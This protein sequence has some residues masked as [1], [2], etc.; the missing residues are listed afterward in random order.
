MC[1]AGFPS[2]SALKSVPVVQE[3]QDMRVRSLGQKDP[4]RRECDPLQFSFLE[5]P[6][7]RGAWWATVHGVAESWT[8]LEPLSSQCARHCVLCRGRQGDRS[9]VP[10]SQGHRHPASASSGS[11]SSCTFLKR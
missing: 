1:K 3:L 11:S 7:D 4:W 10:S 8:Q 5:N 2:G 9:S 6:M